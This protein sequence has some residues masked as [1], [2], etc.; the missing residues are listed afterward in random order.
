MGFARSEV[1]L[2]HALKCCPPGDQ[3]PTPEALAACAPF[4]LAQLLIIRPT[5]IV[6]LG[7][8]VSK[9]LLASPLGITRLR[10]TFAQMQLGQS[11][12]A[13]LTVAVM[14]TY[15][16][17]Y[18]LRNYTPQTRGEMWGDLKQVLQ[19]LGREIPTKRVEHSTRS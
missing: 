15:H 10:G 16:P 5:A 11:S 1:Y 13:P 18:L 6:T 19:M 17:S 9:L 7:G 14:P 4:L 12:A 8:A 2:A 3:A